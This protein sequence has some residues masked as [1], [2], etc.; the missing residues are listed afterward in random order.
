M[1]TYESPLPPWKVLE[2][3]STKYSFYYQWIKNKNGEEKS[4][5]LLKRREL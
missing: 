1:G 4:D 2:S 3:T 5:R